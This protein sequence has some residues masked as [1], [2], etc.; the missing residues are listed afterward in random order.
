MQ[1]VLKVYLICEQLD[2]DG[3]LVDYKDIFKLLWDLQKQTREIKNKSIQY[4]WEFS[5]FSSDYY[6]EHH[7]YP[8]D[9]EI[10]KRKIGRA[11]V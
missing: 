4:C 7:E 10:R 1:K 2:P 9:K 3:S 6:K 11:H 8:N 5:N